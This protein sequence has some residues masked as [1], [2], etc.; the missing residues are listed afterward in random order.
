MSMSI[1]TAVEERM[2]ALESMILDMEEK[3]DDPG[4]RAKAIQGLGVDRMAAGNA[5]LRTLLDMFEEGVAPMRP[6]AVDALLQAVESVKR[7]FYVVTDQAMG[8]QEPQGERFAAAPETAAASLPPG[9]EAKATETILDSGASGAQAPVRRAESATIKVAV[10]RL[11][12]L[13]EAVKA[14]MVSNTVIMQ[15][16][17]DSESNGRAE[18]QA[19][20][21]VRD[22]AKTIDDVRQ[23]VLDMRR[24][25]LAPLF[26]RMGR[27]VRDVAEKTGREVNYVH[28]GGEMELDKSFVDSLADPLVHLLRNAVDHGLES[29]EARLAAGKPA[30][31]RVELRA[32]R[33]DGGAAIEVRDDGKGLSPEVIL[34]KA[35]ERGLADTGRE[36]PISEIYRFI[37]MPGFSTAEQATEVSG[38]GVGMDVAVRALQDMDGDLAIESEPGKGTCFRLLL[39]STRAS[40]EGIADGVVVR[41]AGDYFVLPAEDVVEVVQPGPADIGTVF[42]QGEIVTVRGRGYPLHRLRLLFRLDEDACAAPK[43]AG[44]GLIVV[45]EAGGERR[46]L[47]V[48]D[49]IGREQ[50]VIRGFE[51]FKNLVATPF[52]TGVA[53]IGGLTG[54]VV[55][56]ESVI[57]EAE[58]HGRRACT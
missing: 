29:T 4:L 23:V 30:K 28:A 38:R 52:F 44:D 34:R 46:A 5:P 10:S 35:R 57:A 49:V 7:F 12:E 2:A 39:P 50:M 8:P 6:E 56:L 24:T 31:G 3:P 41:V 19:A 43:N 32:L 1:H 14:L 33:M 15:H 54:A 16:I 58:G 13:M 27:V 9:E 25:P 37:T 40:V 55:H 48:D 18:R 20:D 26:M 42:E 22:H 45:V 17:S 53:V 21:A 51:R 47:L 36:Y 11:D